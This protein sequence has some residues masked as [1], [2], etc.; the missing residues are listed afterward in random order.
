M[1]PGGRFRPENDKSDKA[2]SFVNTTE[3]RSP[4]RQDAFPYPGKEVQMSNTHLF[5]SKLRALYFSSIPD[6]HGKS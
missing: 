3:D 5:F 6:Y 2:A 4:D 1:A